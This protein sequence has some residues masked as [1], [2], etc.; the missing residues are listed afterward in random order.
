M[1]SCDVL[2]S[3]LARP[4]AYQGRMSLAI[5]RPPGVGASS[6][7]WAYQGR[8]SLAID[9]PPGVCASSNAI[10][11]ACAA[12]CVFLVSAR[13]NAF[14]SACAA[15]HFVSACAAAM[16]ASSMD[17]RGGD[18]LTILTA[19]PPEAS[20]VVQWFVLLMDDDTQKYYYLPYAPAEN[21]CIEAEYWAGAPSCEFEQGARTSTYSINFEDMMQKN[22]STGTQRPV[23]RCLQMIP[24]AR[25]PSMDRKLGWTVVHSH[26]P[27]GG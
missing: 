14:V 4:W 16:S 19:K 6:N 20:W 24:D 1:F 13:S 12:V 11:S 8:M 2:W 27:R 7:A 3:A 9:R 18:R 25:P 21:S 23:V 22:L 15:V 26:S 17:L 10:A 5:D